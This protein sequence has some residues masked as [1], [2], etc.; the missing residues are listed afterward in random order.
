LRGFTGNDV[1]VVQNAGDVII[2]LA[3]Q[4]ADEVRTS[5]SYTLAATNAD[6]ETFRTTD[7]A[8]TAA[9]N[10][11]GNGV[12]NLIFGNA[13][14]NQINGGGGADRIIGGRGTDTLIG[15]SEADTFIWREATETGT[16]AN[17][18]DVI[19]D[20]NF[21]AGDRMDVSQIDANIFADG[22]QQFQFIGQNA[23]TLNTA[24]SDPSDVV[25]GQ[26]RYVHA[27]GDTLIQLQTGSS[28]DVEAV[29]RINGIVT[30]EASWFVL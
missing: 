28:P 4:G 19:A 11:T 24:T 27:N 22:N 9:I 23:F 25:P 13:A 2:E 12:A 26:I 20:F 10:L 8:G 16:E 18:A 7:D 30:P 14:N 29:I 21:A 1:Y 5:V 3:N 6:I 17:F 15:G